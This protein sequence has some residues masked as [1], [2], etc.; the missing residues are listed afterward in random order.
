MKDKGKGS[1][2]RGRSPVSHRS[3]LK[4]K[5]GGAWARG[6]CI[7]VGY[8]RGLGRVGADVGSG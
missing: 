3:R 4:D 8:G 5:Q 1:N 2:S 6:V 7:G